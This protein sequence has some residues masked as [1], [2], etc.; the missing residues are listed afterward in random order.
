MEQQ[1][2][3]V[4]EH[5]EEMLLHYGEDVGL[6]IGRKHVAWY[7][8][9]LNG[10]AE[11]RGEIMQCGTTAAVRARLQRFYEPLIERQAA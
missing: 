10:A 6:R 3:T 4:L 1:Y 11:F 5:Y 7:A 8:K 9:G 2:R